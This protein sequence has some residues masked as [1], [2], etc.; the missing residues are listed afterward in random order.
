[1]GNPLN[2]PDFEPGSA[3]GA[4]TGPAFARLRP[5]S[6]CLVTSS[7]ESMD[8][9]QPT[10]ANIHLIAASVVSFFFHI[11]YISIYS[12]PVD[13]TRLH[14]DVLLFSD[15]QN[16]PI[17]KSPSWP[18]HWVCSPF[19]T[20]STEPGDPPDMDSIL[21]QFLSA[22]TL[23]ELPYVKGYCGEFREGI[24]QKAGPRRIPGSSVFF[25]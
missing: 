22:T 9:S 3:G 14:H 16:L 8:V 2:R 4:F 24:V 19:F 7:M 21:S 13:L 6:Q 15:Y 17:R 18:C 5:V 20:L 12:F 23:Q 11:P 25:L 10:V 1:M